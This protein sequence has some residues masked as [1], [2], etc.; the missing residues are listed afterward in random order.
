MYILEHIAHGRVLEC[1][2]WDEFAKKIQRTPYPR[3]DMAQLERY[4]K[5]GSAF[6]YAVNTL[7]AWKKPHDTDTAN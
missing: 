2:T 7:T 3:P 6:S 4:V 1:T 5:Q